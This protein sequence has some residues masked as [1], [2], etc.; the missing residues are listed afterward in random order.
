[1]WETFF[2]TQTHFLGQYAD[3]LSEVEE[4]TPDYF[5]HGLGVVDGY[6]LGSGIGYRYFPIEKL[7][8]QGVFGL[9]ISEYENHP[10]VTSFDIGLSF[11]Y[12]LHRGHRMSYYAVQSN[13]VVNFKRGLG[14]L[15]S[16]IGGMA[17]VRI[18]DRVSLSLSADF[19][20]DFNYDKTE[21]TLL[22]VSFMY[23]F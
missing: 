9:N 1:M 11:L 15:R 10:N 13:R 17:E 3:S 22:G 2:S 5:K 16:G 6:S 20:Y 21:L 18:R 7:G 4:S 23:N 19:S 14:Y 8:V 12:A